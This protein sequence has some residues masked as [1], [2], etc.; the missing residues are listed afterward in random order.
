MPKIIISDTTVLIVFQKNGKLSLLNEIY[1]E[2]ITTLE[3]ADE[4]GKELPG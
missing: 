3:V 4:Y 1:N 2:I